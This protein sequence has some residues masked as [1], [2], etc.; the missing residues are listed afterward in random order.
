MAKP[1]PD[2]KR[3]EDLVSSL[4]RIQTDTTRLNAYREMMRQ[5]LAGWQKPPISSNAMGRRYSSAWVNEAIKEY[6]RDAIEPGLD[7]LPSPAVEIPSSP[8]K[9]Q[10]GSAIP[11]PLP[12][13]VN[14]ERPQ[15]LFHS[16]EAVESNN[17]A[18]EERTFFEQ[19]GA[20]LRYRPAPQRQP[21]RRGA[22]APNV[23]M[24][25]LNMS[26]MLRSGGW[27]DDSINVV[28]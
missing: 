4:P 10:E 6:G 15:R 3:L 14:P 12:S 2:R 19:N 26:Q 20:T 23:Y 24:G 28:P 9:V 18:D 16:R 11:T 7:V 5:G 13:P 1:S 17:R 21:A 8:L 27:P 22:S 25:R